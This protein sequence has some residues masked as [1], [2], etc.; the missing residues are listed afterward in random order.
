LKP[1]GVHVRDSECKGAYCSAAGSSTFPG[2]A[3]CGGSSSSSST[4]TT[5]TTTTITTSGTPDQRADELL[6][7][8]TQA[9]KLQ[10]V[11]GG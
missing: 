2:L 9:E 1:W 3:A 8:M 10:M 7:M 6:A 11:Q 4:T 5:T